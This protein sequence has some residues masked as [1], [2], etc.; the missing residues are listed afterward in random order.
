M[1]SLTLHGPICGSLTRNYSI[2]TSS[3]DMAGRV[4]FFRFPNDH[5]Q[6]RQYTVAGYPAEFWF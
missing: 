5:L 2:S 3:R 6:T 4:D 1:I